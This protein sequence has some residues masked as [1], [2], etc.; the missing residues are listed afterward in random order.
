MPSERTPDKTVKTNNTIYK[1]HSFEGWMEEQNDTSDN[2]RKSMNIESYLHSRILN[3]LSSARNL[4]LFMLMLN[5]NYN[6]WFLIHKCLHKSFKICL[7][8]CLIFRNV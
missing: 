1:K 2:F 6:R 5:R 8:F 3:T 4:C 7:D